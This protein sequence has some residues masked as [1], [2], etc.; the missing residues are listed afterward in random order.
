MVT[1]LSI[2][3]NGP[4]E[5]S[6]NIHMAKL[7]DAFTVSAVLLDPGSSRPHRLHAGI[8]ER[9]RVELSSLIRRRQAPEALSEA[10]RHLHGVKH[11]Q[12]IAAYNHA[13]EAKRAPASS[14]DPQRDK[15]ALSSFHSRQ[16]GTHHW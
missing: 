12:P 2:P 6:H 10:G 13:L 3:T 15:N 7:D 16:P 9:Y 11:W 4:I 8:R 14:L 5:D 1:T